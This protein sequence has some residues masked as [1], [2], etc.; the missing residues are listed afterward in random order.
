MPEGTRTKSVRRAVV[1]TGLL[2][3]LLGA[4][5]VRRAFGAGPWYVNG[6]GGSDAN[7][8]LASSPGAPGAGPCLT[9]GA[10]IDKGRPA[11]RC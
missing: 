11:T 10:A 9:V 8:C 5:G 4:G 2:I 3:G 6:V 7:D 1:L